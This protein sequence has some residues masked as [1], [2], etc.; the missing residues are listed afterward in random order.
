MPNTEAVVLTNMCMITDGSKV[1]VQ[2]AD[3]LWSLPGGKVEPNEPFVTSVIREVY[4]ETGL[5]IADVQ[6][7][8]VK[9]FTHSQ[10]HYRYA[11]FLYMTST[12]SR[13]AYLY[14]RIRDFLS[15]GC[16]NHCPLL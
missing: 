15:P 3:E 6:L 11:V 5:R 13:G 9:Q 8:G 16:C 1:L 2:E 7:C 4:E 12:F 14:L 10:G